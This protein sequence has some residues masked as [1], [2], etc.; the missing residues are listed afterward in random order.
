MRRKTCLPLVLILVAAYGG[1]A[2]HPRCR[3]TAPSWASTCRAACR[4]CSPP[5]ATPTR[6]P[7][8]PGAGDHPRPG[9]RP[10]RGR[11]RHHPPGRR[12]RRPAAGREEPR[13]G[14]RRSSA[15]PPS[16]GSGPCSQLAQFP[17]GDGRRRP[18]GGRRPGGRDTSTTVPGDTTTTT[19]PGAARTTPRPRRRP[20]TRPRPRGHGGRAPAP[21]GWSRA[22]APPVRPRSRRRPRRPR[23]RPPRRRRTDPTATTVAGRDPEP[24]EVPPLTP[25]DQ[26]VADQPVH[27]GRRRRHAPSTSSARRWRPAASSRP[28]SA[29]IQN[30][31]WL[32]RLE[33]RGGEDGIDKFNEIAATCYAQAPDPQVCPTGPARHRP[34]LGGAVGADDP[35]AE[36]RG[37]PDPDLRQLHRVRG[38]GPGPRAALRLAAGRARA[39][40]R[41]DRVGLARRR[42]AAGRHHRRHR[43][44]RP[45]RR[46]TCCSTTGRSGWW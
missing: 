36:L 42:L 23:R 25:R 33:M 21:P 5:R 10:R 24:Q 19:A 32:V 11:A 45:R 40:E 38:Q 20:P 28:A 13:P 9:R 15:R 3:A 18:G 29:D 12:H 22:R 2:R 35:A 34:R 43:R 16:C 41:A 6:R 30:G 44:P 8:R 39:A 4:S 37:R 7:A 31:Q 26:D 14:A 27:P 1:L 17:E 46:S